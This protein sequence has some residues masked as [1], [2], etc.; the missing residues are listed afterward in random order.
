MEQV[1]ITVIIVTA[2][3]EMKHQLKTVVL[4]KDGTCSVKLC[5]MCK[6]TELYSSQCRNKSGSKVTFTQYKRLTCIFTMIKLFI[7]I[8]TML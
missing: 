6:V 3:L 4:F 2:A 1:Y 5:A 8:V 7:K